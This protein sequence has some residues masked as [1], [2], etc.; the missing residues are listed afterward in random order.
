MKNN[1]EADEHVQKCLNP[2]CRAIL[3]ISRKRKSETE[4]IEVNKNRKS[5]MKCDKKGYFIECLK[6]G[7]K[8]KL[9]RN[10]TPPG[11]GIQWKID[12]LRD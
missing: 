6:C 1:Y 8:H 2:N 9:K 10:P 5:Q 11:T 12:G 4:V 7:A 3:F